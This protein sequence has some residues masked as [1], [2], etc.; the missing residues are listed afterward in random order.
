M[1][2]S[3]SILLPLLPYTDTSSSILLL[4]VAV[5]EKRLM[6]SQVRWRGIPALMAYPEWHDDVA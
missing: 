6:E 1:D 4:Q 3:P 2:T 5:T